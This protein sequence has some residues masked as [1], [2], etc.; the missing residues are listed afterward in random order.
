MLLYKDIV[1]KVKQDKDYKIPVEANKILIDGLLQ[2]LDNP[3]LKSQYKDVEEYIYNNVVQRVSAY[4]NNKRFGQLTIISNGILILTVKFQCGVFNTATFYKVYNNG[5]DGVDGIDI[6]NNNI[7][8]S[9]N[10][11]NNQTKGN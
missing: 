1:S 8:W 11:K 9:Q 5:A 4:I 10:R 3:Y 7:I 6:F 2:L